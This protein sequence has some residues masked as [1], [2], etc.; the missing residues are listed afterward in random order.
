MQRTWI[1]AA[2]SAVLGGLFVYVVFVRSPAS[3]P[4]KGVADPPPPPANLEQDIAALRR[5]VFQLQLR[6][7]Q[8]AM[9]GEGAKAAVPAVANIRERPSL[10][11]MRA[12]LDH[13][14]GETTNPEMERA[15]LQR[16]DHLLTGER[17]EPKWATDTEQQ[18]EAVVGTVE[19]LGTLQ[20]VKCMSTLC[21]AVVKVDPSKRQELI[22]KIASKEPFGG[23][24]RFSYEGPLATMY[25]A[26]RGHKLPDEVE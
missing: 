1:A 9:A 18:V 5:E 21:K 2:G 3:V 11:E 22:M 14:R 8:R 6:D 26:R 17:R 23:G 20:E 12:H 10:D 15:Y 13:G 7:T 19:S 16:L 24:T 4:S 25:I